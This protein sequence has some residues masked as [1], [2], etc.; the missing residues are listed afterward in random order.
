MID[1][2]DTQASRH[3]DGGRRLCPVFL[4]V[5]VTSANPGWQ[6]GDTALFAIR[7]PRQ[8]LLQRLP[9]DH[10]AAEVSTVQL[11]D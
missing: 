5:L 9:Y 4:G 2:V 1:V 10:C 8:H 7:E 3:R 6:S 11:D